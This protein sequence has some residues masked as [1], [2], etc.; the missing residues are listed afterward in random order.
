MG[1][2]VSLAMLLAL[3]MMCFGRVCKKPEHQTFTKIGIFLVVVLGVWNAAW[4]GFQNIPS[5]WGITALLSGIVMLLAGQFVYLE[6]THSSIVRHARYFD[7]KLVTMMVL[8][9]YLLLYVVTIIQMNLGMP[10][11]S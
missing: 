3:L 9:L 5:F 7:V 10:I 2:V 1:I 6:I 8:G 4:Y 11:I